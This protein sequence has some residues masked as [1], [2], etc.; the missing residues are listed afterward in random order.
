M[1]PQHSMQNR[2]AA[3]DLTQRLADGRRGL[4]DSEKR[5]RVWSVATDGNANAE[6]FELASRSTPDRC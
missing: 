1:L 6:V 3:P 5:D 4:S 2:R